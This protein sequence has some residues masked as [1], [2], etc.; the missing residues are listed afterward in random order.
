[1]R[2]L[3]EE[4]KPFLKPEIWHRMYIDRSRWIAGIRLENP[5]S[6]RGAFRM[7]VEQLL[8]DVTLDGWDTHGTLALKQAQQPATMANDG[9]LQKLVL[10]IGLAVESC[11]RV[12]HYMTYSIEKK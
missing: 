5:R 1:M 11:C 7:R 4:I 10:N 6:T 3:F 2:D 9:G 8:V 12:L